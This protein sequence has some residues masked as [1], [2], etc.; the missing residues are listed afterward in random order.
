MKFREYPQRPLVGVGVC[1]LEDNKVL[2][3]RRR[4]PPKIGE[5]SLPGG[6]Q[7]IGE[8]IKECA[9]REVREET[10]L[11]VRILKLID[12]IDSIIVDD[13]GKIKYHYTLIDFVAEPVSGNLLAGDDAS[14]VK[15]FCQKKVIDLPIW[16]QTKKVIAQAFKIKDQ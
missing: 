3:A 12:V 6:A 11:E 7:E 4:S 16:D 9:L 15:W 13:F 10:G 5:W 8:T 14:H 2:L 1:V